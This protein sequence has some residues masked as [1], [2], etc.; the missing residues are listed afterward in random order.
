MRRLITTW[1]QRWR[2]MRS[3]GIRRAELSTTRCQA[4]PEFAMPQ[5]TLQQALELALQ[6]HQAGRLGQAEHLY[7]QVLS[8][9]PRHPDALHLMG[10]LASQNG[11]HDA[12]IGFIE[13]AIAIT[14]DNP[15]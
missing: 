8:H 12:A 13:R 7:R 14:P 1:P 15:E 3:S 11:Q 9:A 5:L 10:V 2:A 4:N 6:H